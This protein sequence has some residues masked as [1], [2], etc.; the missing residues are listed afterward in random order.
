MGYRNRTEIVTGGTGS[1]SFMSFSLQYSALRR[2]LSISI[3]AVLR[4]ALKCCGQMLE[5]S[6][7]PRLLTRGRG[8]RKS[9]V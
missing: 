5:V 4:N 8:D 3:E 2:Q 6:F 1:T 7:Q 9:V